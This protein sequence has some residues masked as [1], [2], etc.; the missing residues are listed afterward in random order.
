MEIT[1]GISSCPNDTY[2]FDALIH[3]KIDT[4]GIDFKVVV[5][6]VQELNRRAMIGDLQMTKLSYFAYSQVYK[7]YQILDAGSALG[8]A[9]GPLFICKKGNESAINSKSKILIPGKETTANLLFSMAYPDFKDKTECLF[10]EIEPKIMSGEYDAGVIIHENRFTYAERGFA[11]LRDLGNFWESETHTPIPL[12]A[13]TIRRDVPNDLKLTINQLLRESIEYANQN[14]QASNTF[15]H[16][17]AQAIEDDVLKKH[18]ALFVNDFSLSL[19]EQ[20]MA[21]IKTLY[22]RAHSLQII[23]EEPTDMFIL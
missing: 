4:K 21:A 5:A 22:S 17:Y 16:E 9:N 7:N 13:I 15:I 11:M 20:G 12:G 18:I 23:S 6:D 8:F 1:L 14:P 10:S 19:G 3:K 2:T